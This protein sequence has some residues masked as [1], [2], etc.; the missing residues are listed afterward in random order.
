MFKLVLI[1]IFTFATLKSIVADE[2]SLKEFVTLTGTCSSAEKTD[3]LRGALEQTLIPKLSY[4]I[5]EAPVYGGRNTLT[6]ATIE[7]LEFVFCLAKDKGK[8]LVTATDNLD[9]TCGWVDEKHLSSIKETSSLALSNLSPCGSKIQPMTVGSFCEKISKF[10]KLPEDLK[11]LTGFCEA[12]GLNSTVDIKFIN[13]IQYPVTYLTSSLENSRLKLSAYHDKNRINLRQNIDN[14]SMF[15]IYQIAK[16]DEG[17]VVVL[18]GKNNNLLGWV[19]LREGYL[20]HTNL[21]TFFSEKGNEK[22]YLKKEDTTNFTD[23][24][25]LFDTPKESDRKNKKETPKFP[26]IRDLRKEENTNPDFVPSLEVA[27]IGKVCENMGLSLL[28][29]WN[30]SDEISDKKFILGNLETSLQGEKE[31]NWKYFVTLDSTELYQLYDKTDEIC[32]T[33]DSGNS[34]KVATDAILSIVQILTGDK[35][36][37]EELRDQLLEGSIPLQTATIIGDGMTDFLIRATTGDQLDYYQ[38]EFCRTNVL[39]ES[40]QRN[41]KIKNPEEGKDLVWN[42]D[43]YEVKKDFDFKWAYKDELGQEIYYVPV[44]YLPRKIASTINSPL[45]NPLTQ[46][47]LENF[48]DKIKSCWFDPPAEIKLTLYMELGQDGRVKKN[49]I[50]LVEVFGGDKNQQRLAFEKAR[51]AIIICE[52]DGYSLPPKKYESWKEVEITFN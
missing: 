51:R 12:G 24:L 37:P 20:W 21:S 32:F 14:P 17:E 18:L 13:R 42:G 38:K 23:Q 47:E 3:L 50:R 11:T 48:S 49:S 30:Q 40:M 46:M 27:V 31:T 5:S 34:T 44:G 9:K 15:Y 16:T 52:Q 19:S 4:T 25:T 28:C 39:I 2:I 10:D 8:I 1:L 29:S 41:K 43:A 26:V 6:G 36:L 35:K 45:K 7:P 22:V 33:L